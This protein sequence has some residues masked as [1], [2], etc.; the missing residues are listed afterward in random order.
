MALVPDQGPVQ[1]LTP[2]AA[3]SVG[4]DYWILPRRTSRLGS[5]LSDHFGCLPARTLSAQLPDGADRHQ[6]SKDAELL[7][8]RHENTVLRR[9]VACGVPKP[10]SR[11]L[12]CGFLKRTADPPAAR[13][14]ACL[15]EVHDRYSAGIHPARVRHRRASSRL[16]RNA[17]AKGRPSLASGTGG[18]ILYCPERC[19]TQEYLAATVAFRAIGLDLCGSVLAPC[20]LGCA[21]TGR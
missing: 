3:D 11:L 7:V 21:G 10:R 1:Q 15:C 9:Q 16:T 18:H 4:L 8:L 2:T 6:V 17:H 13:Q 14:A 20:L 19:A 12:T 5:S